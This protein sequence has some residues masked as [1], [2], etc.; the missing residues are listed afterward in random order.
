MAACQHVLFGS[1][2]H[3]HTH[4]PA[5]TYAHVCKQRNSADIEDITTARKKKFYFF[6]ARLI[7]IE[8][9][10]RKK[11]GRDKSA[12]PKPEKKRNRLSFFFFLFVFCK[13]Y[14]VSKYRFHHTK[15]NINHTHQ[16]L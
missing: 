13:R 9:P 15:N 11:K 10:A 1:R 12:A 5:H 14:Q 3:T 7:R 8:R 4:S 6:K 16:L 2:T